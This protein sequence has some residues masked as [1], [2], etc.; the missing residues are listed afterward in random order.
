MV[1]SQP[2]R[3]LSTPPNVFAGLSNAFR[4]MLIGLVELVPGVSG[5]TV[6]LV[7]GVFE[8]LVLSAN[9]LVGA[10]THAVS[11]RD[12]RGAA[13]QLGKVEWGLLLPLAAGMFLALFALSGPLHHFVENHPVVASALFLGMVSASLLVPITMAREAD[14][15]APTPKVAEIGIV[16]AVGLA[17]F[18]LLGLPAGQVESPAAWVIVLSGAVAVCA[19]AMP[20]LSGSFILLAFGMYQPTLAAVSQRDFGYLG[21]FVAGAVVG[22]ASIVRV[23]AYLLR[24]HRRLTLLVATGLILGSLRALWPWQQGPTLLWPG[25]EPWGWPL[26]AGLAGAALVLLLWWRERR[27]DKDLR[28]AEF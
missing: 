5:G 20:G 17:A 23:L 1:S 8:R 12:G 2:P 14:P 16:L 25:E 9:H 27:A 7:L 10:V 3:S 4:G 6:A 18:L 26:V 13:N 19:L 15:A 24:V 21:M 28:P 22:L 11:K